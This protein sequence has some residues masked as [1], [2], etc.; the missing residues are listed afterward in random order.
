M[1]D[2]KARAANRPERR[3]G[4]PS[5]AIDPVT[6]Q[7]GARARARG[8][9]NPPRSVKSSAG[10]TPLGEHLRRAAVGSRV[11]APLKAFGSH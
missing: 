4:P 9:S 6:G 3:F 11:D 1:T 2:A 5:Q 8:K 10:H 7:S